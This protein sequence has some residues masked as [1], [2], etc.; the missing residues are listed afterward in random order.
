MSHDHDISNTELDTQLVYLGRDPKRDCGSVNPPVHRTSTV[1]FND[2]ASL[3]DYENGNKLGH[4]GYGRYGSP[5]IDGLEEALVALEGADHALVTSSGLAAITTALLA[6]LNAGDHALIPDS[7]YSSARHFVD[8]ELVRMGVEVQ[9]YDPT[10]GAD[11]ATLMK[12]NTKV[13]YCESPGSLTFEMQDIPAIAKVAH[14]AGAVV[15][16]DNTWATPLLQ[17]PFDLGV[18]IS[19]HS[20]TKYIGGHSDLVMGVMLCKKKHFAQLNRAHRN[21]GAIPSG[22]NAYLAL[23]GLRTIAVRLKQHEAHALEVAKWLQTVPEVKR[24]LFPALPDDPG[25]AIWKRDMTGSCGLF[26]LEIGQVDETAL[27]RM[28]DGL[29]HFGMGFSWGGFESLVIAYQPAK[30]R[31][32]TRWEKGSTFLRLNI[33]LEAPK[34]LIADLDAGF[35]RLRAGLKKSA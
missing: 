22:D 33:G 3:K 25:H 13:I 27:S 29:K 6:F 14:A 18:D 11:I 17:K 19:I 1:I 15:L 10:I 34:D 28:L 16:A 2:Y 24:V 26:A 5:T 21:I 31:T 9:F 32:A 30:M 8:H 20:A 7:L 23:R 12:P 35:A 4:R